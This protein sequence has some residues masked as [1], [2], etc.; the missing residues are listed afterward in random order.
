MFVA[1]DTKGISQGVYDVLKSKILSCELV[2]GRRLDLAQ[3]SSQLGVSRTPVKDALQRLSVQDLVEIHPRRGTVVTNVT[4][5][6][7]REIFEVREAL[8][9]KACDLISGNLKRETVEVLRDLNRRMFEPSFRFVDHAVLDGEFHR[10]IIEAP[11]NRQLV[12]VYSELKA[13]ILLA[14]VHYH[15]TTWRNNSASTTA[16]HGNIIEAL[17]EGRSEDA[18]RWMQVHLRNSMERLISGIAQTA[19][20][21]TTVI[22][23]PRT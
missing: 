6:G 5:Q 10:L 21:R 7:V 2:A 13:H 16:E 20:S 18:N 1:L 3:I 4:P 17:A 15:S 12:R 14:R 19:N 22:T 11:G 9:R 8:E 23:E